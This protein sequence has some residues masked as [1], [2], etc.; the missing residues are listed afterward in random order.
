[1]AM[2]LFLVGSLVFVIGFIS[3]IKPIKKLRI[4]SRKTGSIVLMIGL[5]VGLTGAAIGG[6]E[7]R[8]AKLA[9]ETG[10]STVV[11]YEPV[12][13]VEEDRLAAE[14]EPSSSVP[15][16][17]LTVQVTHQSR[18]YG[19]WRSE[20][21][22]N[23]CTERVSEFSDN[24]SVTFIYNDTMRKNSMEPVVLR[25]RAE[26]LV[27]GEVIFVKTIG[28]GGEGVDAYRQS[29]DHKIERL[30]VIKPD[31]SKF[32]YTE[33]TVPPLDSLRTGEPL[34]SALVRCGS[35]ADR[36]IASLDGAQNAIMRTQQSV[37]SRI[38]HDDDVTLAFNLAWM[39]EVDQKC[40]FLV[41]DFLGNRYNSQLFSVTAGT[42]EN[43]RKRM[44]MDEYNA[45]ITIGIADAKVDSC[46]SP[47]LKTKFWNLWEVVKSVG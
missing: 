37:R 35:E 14:D 5:V 2:T 19:R 25:F 17:P 6:G 15:P 18:L 47:I 3:I 40:D 26:Y 46:N 10:Y 29:G 4:D 20:K 11:K 33:M 41:K 28:K 43:L 23:G 36:F 45:A 32:G 42:N 9:R 44:N 7:L 21:E 30:A 39:S 13:R 27:F 1:M 34:G 16:K 12:K 38:G 22:A 8:E 24:A 31:G